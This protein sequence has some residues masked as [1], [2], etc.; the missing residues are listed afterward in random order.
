MVNRTQQILLQLVRAEGP[1]TAQEIA[2]RI[3]VCARTVRSEI[4]A[5]TRELE[6]A[7]ATLVARRNY[8]YRIQVHD[9]ALFGEFCQQLSIKSMQ[10]A[11]A[12]YDETTRMLFICRSIMGSPEGVRIDELSEQLS[13]TRS[14]LRE[15]LRRAT[16]FF[17]S[18]GL[19][20]RSTPGRGLSLSGDEYRL[21]VAMTELLAAHFHKA[22]ND[23]FDEGYARLVRCDERERQDIRHAYLSVQRDS[24][25]ALRDSLSQRVAAYL[26]IA[27]NRFADGHV[28]SVGDRVRGLV[29]TSPVYD[30]ARRTL[31][32]LSLE[33]AGFELGGDE[34]DA[35][36]VL[37][38]CDLDLRRGQ[39][40]RRALPGAEGD[41]ARATDVAL[42]ALRARAGVDLE[43]VPGALDVLRSTLATPV[44]EHLLG[45]DGQ[46]RFW[47]SNEVA[48]KRSPVVVALARIM[49]QGLEDELRL[50][51]SEGTMNLLAAFAA[52][53]LEGAE[54]PIRPL[55]V[56]VTDGMGIEFARRKGES[57]RHRFPALVA[58]LH[59]CELYEIR[60]YDERD[61]DIV[62]TDSLPVSY[63]YAYPMARLR[64]GDGEREYAQVFNKV[65]VNAY[66][67]DG[68]LPSAAALDVL[69]GCEV[70]TERQFAQ[71]VAASVHAGPDER[72]A[73]EKRLARDL[74]TA[75]PLCAGSVGAIVDP[76]RSED[77]ERIML[78]ELRRPVVWRGAKLSRLVY[79]RLCLSGGLCAMRVRE[80]IV[81][82][83]VER[84]AKSKDGERDLV[85]LA[86]YSDDPTALYEQLAR[87]SLRSS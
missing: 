13:L 76:C 72:R 48:Y 38:M 24:G 15:P 1:L 9:D 60:G 12:S 18:Y 44:V 87:D 58:S 51:P 49:M 67:L 59:P 81:A 69:T 64:L 3:G 41:V 45:M 31:E 37:L 86:A 25:W 62:L 73:A 55:R 52:W 74:G 71:L 82:L 10:I 23:S 80:R 17:E 50:A 20:M 47:H 63:N 4:P 26:V 21:R 66:Q 78:Y 27:R 68:L 70:A 8:G 5:I 33:F 77:D 32:R 14:A 2:S 39:D 22:V 42:R 11:Q 40:L 79:A 46:E 30:L 6:R 36:A 84:L 53:C 43:E 57:L 19:K 65:L 35:L 75:S 34:A 56:L 16:S 7:G 29:R 54:Y 85:E 83:L 28:V 61:Y